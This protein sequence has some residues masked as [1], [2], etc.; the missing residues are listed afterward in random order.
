MADA[1]AIPRWIHGIESL[2]QIAVEFDRIGDFQ[3]SRS[4]LVSTLVLIS[5]HRDSQR[6]VRRAAARSHRKC[7]RCPPCRDLYASVRALEAAHSLASASWANSSRQA[8]KR[9]ALIGL[10]R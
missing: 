10:L 5:A 7:F 1:T 3:A 6:C 9:S 4:V 8:R 2:A